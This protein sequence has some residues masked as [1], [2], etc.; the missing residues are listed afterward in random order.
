MNNTLFKSLGLAACL[1]VTAVVQAK[2][3]W[4]DELDLSTMTSGYLTP[5]L[6]KSIDGNALMING[7]KYDRGVGAHADSRVVFQLDGKVT[8][9]QAVVGVDDE[10]NPTA[11]VQYLVIADGAVLFDS[12]IL[13]MKESKK[14]DVDLTGKK[15]LTLILNDGGDGNVADHADWA[16]AKVSFD[17]KAP[18]PYQSDTRWA[19]QKDGS[20]MWTLANDPLAIGHHDHVEMSGQFTSII[21]RYGINMDGTL[22]ISR[23]IVWPMLR[24]IPN[25]THGSLAQDFDGPLLPEITV[26]GKPLGKEKPL[27]ISQN[28]IMTVRSEVGEGLELTRVISSSVKKPV[29]VE[30]FTLKNTGE[31]SRKVELNSLKEEIETDPAKGVD[32]AYVL[33]S[34]SSK[35]AN[36][37]LAPGKSMTFTVVHSGR[38]A[39]EKPLAVDA[40][41]ELNDRLAWLKGI[42]HELVFDSPDAVVN[43]MFGFAKIRATESIFKTKGGMMHA[44]GGGRYYAAIWANDQAEY[45]NPLFA[46]LGDPV[47]RESAENTFRHFARFMNKEW[48]PMPSSIIAEGDD[49][50]AGAGDRGDA[51]MIAYGATRYA[52]AHGDKKVAEQLWPLIEWCLEYNIRK[53]NKDGVIAS[54][55]DELEGRFKAGDANLCTSSLA[56]DAFKS[57]AALGRELGKSKELTAKYDKHA[58][59]LRKSIDSFFGHQVEGFDTYRYFKENTLLRSWICIPLTVG[60]KR[61]KRSSRTDF[62]LRTGWLRRPETRRSGIAPHFMDF[63]EFSLPERRKRRLSILRNTPPADSWAIT[64]LMR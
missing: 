24:T 36:V 31:K 45:V 35:D 10:A 44:P 38:R 51:A 4:L 11:S 14:V 41:K 17:G 9:F 57:A 23:H 61:S 6:K 48:K 16:D 12:G 20:V 13:K 60:T 58:V 64:S 54:R 52:M 8:R 43:R 37:T 30:V 62:G 50:W 29:A 19:I 3:V 2:D 55:T 34:D 26:D 32:G 15:F 22:K 27:T 21:V 47:A 40:V 7:K 1:S 49:I 18:M 28:G 5:Q 25:D 56:Y 33:S 53:I 63:A 39:S 59:D 46:Y 42:D